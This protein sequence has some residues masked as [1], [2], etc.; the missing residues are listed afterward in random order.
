M[1]RRRSC[2]V[3]GVDDG[4]GNTVG[5]VEKMDS[6]RNDSRSR[7]YPL[8]TDGKDLV[9]AAQDVT[10]EGSGLLVKKGAVA[11]ARWEDHE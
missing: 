11:A 5:Y 7:M 3:T 2:Q 4:L 1:S 9:P 8:G 6:R 10:L